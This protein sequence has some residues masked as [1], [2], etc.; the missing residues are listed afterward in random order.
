MARTG[1]TPELIVVGI[2]NAGDEMR[3]RDYTPPYMRLDADG[4]AT[5]QAHRFLEFLGKELI[6]DIDRGYRTTPAR[7]LAGHSRGGLFVVYSLIE[8]PDLFDARLA[9][10]PALWRDDGRIVAELAKWLGKPAGR[11]AYLYLSL[12]DRENEKMR[13]AFDHATALLRTRSGP[14]LPWRADITAGAN[15]QNNALLATPVGLHEYFATAR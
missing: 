1:V 14:S 5:G 4:A 6:A 12:G 15:H 10:S 3:R 7:M 2:P 8:A 13:R 9:H 11:P